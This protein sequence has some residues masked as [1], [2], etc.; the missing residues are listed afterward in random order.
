MGLLFWPDIGN[1]QSQQISLGTPFSSSQDVLVFLFQIF[2]LKLHMLC[3]PVD[4]AL[5]LDKRHILDDQ[6]DGPLYLSPPVC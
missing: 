3:C 5:A 2:S 1:C 6:S 4:R